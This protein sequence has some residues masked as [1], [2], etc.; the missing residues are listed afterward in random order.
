MI[1]SPRCNYMAL[2]HLITLNTS[3]WCDLLPCIAMLCNVN[4]LQRLHRQI[5]SEDVISAWNYQIYLH[6]C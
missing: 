5:K 6:T 3:N 4:V 2:E 1:R